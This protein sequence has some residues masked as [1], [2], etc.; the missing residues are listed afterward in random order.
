MVFLSTHS[1]I[2]YKINKKIKRHL[3]QAEQNG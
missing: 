2:F 1:T 3:A